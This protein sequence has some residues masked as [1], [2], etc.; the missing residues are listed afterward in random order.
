MK[1]FKVGAL[2]IYNGKKY[3]VVSVNENGSIYD[4]LIAEKFEGDEIGQPFG[5][6]E[7]DLEAA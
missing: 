4:Y 5:V 1:N 6:L 2:V 3:V 7:K